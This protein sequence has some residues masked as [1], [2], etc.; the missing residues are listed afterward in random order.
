[1]LHKRSKLKYILTNRSKYAI[2]NKGDTMDKLG[3][4][5]RTIRNKKHI[6]LKTVYSDIGIS[7]SK[8]CKLENGL[9]EI[10]LCDFFKL[11]RY[12]G[13]SPINVLMKCGYINDRDAS[14]Y[15]LMFNNADKLG[16]EDIKLVQELI[17]RLTKRECKYV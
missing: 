17:D 10:L 6:A 12:Y 9:S 4:A 13:V 11:V 7:D 2:M 8:L 14:I 15:C 1:M 16:N 5:L 3:K